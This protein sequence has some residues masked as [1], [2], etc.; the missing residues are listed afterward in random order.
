M[1]P[2]LVFADCVQVNSSS[3][4]PLLQLQPSPA[5]L[6]LHGLMHAL[7]VH[8]R[9]WQLCCARSVRRLQVCVFR[10]IACP[11]LPFMAHTA[12][13]QGSLITSVLFFL[14]IFVT[15]LWDQAKAHWEILQHPVGLGGQEMDP[16]GSLVRPSLRD[17]A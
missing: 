14:V 15:Y 7:H 10:L 3:L 4:P 6:A 12:P 5:C 8:I 1:H 11:A 16:V 9:C 2:V 17:G 13:L